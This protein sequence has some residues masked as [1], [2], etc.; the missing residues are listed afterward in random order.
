MTLNPALFS[1]ASENWATPRGLAKQLVEEFGIELD[2]CATA[3]NAVVP[4]F[5]SKEDNGLLQE[6]TG[7]VWMNPP[8]GRG[9]GHWIK[10]ASDSAKAGATVVCL[11]PSRTDTKLWHDYI[12]PI[13]R[14]ERNGEIRFVKGRLKFGESKNSAPFPSAIIVFKP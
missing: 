5:F 13:R 2:V 3:E 14:G 10:K 8:Y 7:S 12:E 9:M 4:R 6:W 1:S 11:I